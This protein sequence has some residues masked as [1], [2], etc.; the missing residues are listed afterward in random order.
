MSETKNFIPS[1]IPPGSVKAKIVGFELKVRPYKTKEG[2]PIT[3]II[4]NLNTDSIGG[5]FRGL[6]KDYN[7]PNSEHYLCQVGRCRISEWGFSKGKT[8]SGVEVDPE[9][10]MLRAL[11][12]LCMEIGELKWF[13][14]V[15]NTLPTV[16]EMIKQINESNIF[17]NFY[18][19]FTIASRQYLNKK[20][21]VTD[22]LYLPRY[23]KEAGKPFSK[24]MD[25]L[26]KFNSTVHV[27]KPRVAGSKAGPEQPPVMDDNDDLPF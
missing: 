14:D 4:L 3:D 25:D 6:K 1:V 21:Y 7:D 10:D 27:M 20:N 5:T 24:K 17:K 22:D 18:L 13:Q 12:S 11:K 2:D 23:S 9:K 19:Y 16:A 8:K 26:I 15:D